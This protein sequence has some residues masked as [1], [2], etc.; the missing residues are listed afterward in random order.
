MANL[1]SEERR[2]RYSTIARKEDIEQSEARKD[3]NLNTKADERRSRYASKDYL[4][5]YNA[6]HAPTR[7]D[8]SAVNRYLNAYGLNQQRQADRMQEY[9][10]RY[11]QQQ[12]MNAQRDAIRNG[13]DNGNNPLGLK[14]LENPLDDMRRLEA[15]KEAYGKNHKLSYDESQKLEKAYGKYNRK[16]L[17]QL[18]EHFKNAPER[19]YSGEIAWVNEKLLKTA[20]GKENIQ[21][22]NILE[23]QIKDAD[24]RLERLQEAYA[25]RLVGGGTDNGDY[26]D[27]LNQIKQ[28]KSQLQNELNDYKELTNYSDQDDFAKY[29][30]LGESNPNNPVRFFRTHND[31]QANAIFDPTIRNEVDT[32]HHESTY[33]GGGSN[34]SDRALYRAITDEEADNYSYIL[35][36]YGQEEADK[37][38]QAVAKHTDVNGSLTALQEAQEQGYKNPLLRTAESIGLGLIT[39]VEAAKNLISGDEFRTY[40]D[41]KLAGRQEALRSGAAEKLTGGNEIG[42]FLYNTATSAADNLLRYAVGGGIGAATGEAGAAEGTMRLMM[43]GQVMDSAMK[44]ALDRGLSDSQAVTTALISAV[45][46]E[47]FETIS[48]SNLKAMQSVTPKNYRQL[49]KNI[50]KQFLG[51]GSEEMFTDIGNAIADDLVNGEKS[52]I[53]QNILNYMKQGMSEE[54]AKKQASVDFALQLVESGLSGGITGAAMGGAVAVD[55]AK[56]I[57]ANQKY[58]E[59]FN[60]YKESGLSEEDAV[61]TAL[62]EV[63]NGLQTV[64]DKKGNVK[65]YKG[66][67]KSIDKAIA[68]AKTINENVKNIEAEMNGVAPVSEEDIRDNEENIRDNEVNNEYLTDM[69]RVLSH[70]D[71][72][73]D[74]QAQQFLSDQDEMVAKYPDK[75]DE[76]IKATVD[77][78]MNGK[79]NAEVFDSIANKVTNTM[80]KNKTSLES[81]NTTSESISQK[82]DKPAKVDFKANVNGEE[83]VITSVN[84]DNMTI[85][86]SVGNETTIPINAAEMSDGASAAVEQAKQYGKRGSRLYL[87]NM[88]GNIRDY[89]YTFNDFY[90]AGK[91]GKEFYGRNTRGLDTDFLREVYDAGVQDGTKASKTGGL[92]RND[93]RYT[94]Q[95]SEARVLDAVG[96]A[97]NVTIQM[98]HMLSHDANGYLSDG[99]IHISTSAEKPSLVVFS[100]EFTHRLEDT[101]P[102]AYKAYKDYVIDYLKKTSDEEGNNVYETREIDLKNAYARQG[103]ELSDKELQDE[104]VANAT[105]SF[106]S[107]TDFIED[108]VKEN[109]SLAQQILDVLKQMLEDLKNVFAENYDAKSKEGKALQ[110]DLEAREEAL[111]LWTNAIKNQNKKDVKKNDTRYSMKKLEN[112]YNKFSLKEDSEG[113]KLSKEQQEFFKDSK[114]VDDEGNLLVMYHGS[115]QKFTEFNL[116]AKGVLNGRVLGDGFYFTNYKKRADYYGKRGKVFKVYLNIKNPLYFT[117]TTKTPDKIKKIL[118]ESNEKKYEEYKKDESWWGNKKNISKDKYINDNRNNY[119]Y[120]RDA[121]YELQFLYGSD[122]NVASTDDVTRILKDLGYDGIIFDSKKKNE[123]E[124]VAFY[125]NQVKNVDNKKPTDNPDIR[126]SLKE[127]SDYEKAIRYGELKNKSNTELEVEYDKAVKEGNKTDAELIV[128]R[129]AKNKGYTTELYHGTQQFGFTKMD[130]NKSD[131]NI[132]VFATSSNEMASSYSGTNRIRQVNETNPLSDEEKLKL[133]KDSG[134]WKDVRYFKAN[135]EKQRLDY[136]KEQ[137]KR[138]N[139]W[140]KQN[141]KELYDRNLMSDYRKFSNNLAEGILFQNIDVE[142]ALKELE[143]LQNAH[144]VISDYANDMWYALQLLRGRNVKKSWFYLD[145]RFE[146][147]GRIGEYN[148]ANDNAGNYHLYANTDGMLDINAQ[149]SNWNDILGWHRNYI[150]SFNLDNTDLKKEGD[151]VVLYSKDGIKLLSKKTSDDLSDELKKDMLELFVDKESRKEPGNTTRQI[152]KYAKDAGYTGVIYRNLYDNGGRNTTSAF[153]DKANVY[154]FFNPQEQLK[155]ADPVTYDDEGNVI[156]LSERFNKSNDDIRFSLK[157]QEKNDTA[158]LITR[159]FDDGSSDTFIKLTNVSKITDKQWDEIYN[160]INPYYLGFDY[161]KNPQGLKQKAEDRIKENGS[162]TLDA[163]NQEDIY[164]IATILGLEHEDSEGNMLSKEQQDYFKDSIIRDKNGKLKVV[165]HGSPKDFTQFDYK[166]IGTTGSAEGYGFYFTDE[167]DKASGYTTS[168]GGKIYEGYLNLTK[169]LSL[170][171]RTLK[172]SQVSKLIK[173]LDPTGDDIVSAY[174]STSDGY[175]SKAWYNNSLNEALDNLMENTTD[176][177]IISEIA[178]IMGTKEILS[179]VRKV[180]GYDGFIAKDKYDNGE[181]YVVFDSNQFKNI[182]NKTPTDNPDIRFSLKEE[183]NITRNDVAALTGSNEYMSEAVKDLEETLNNRYGDLLFD[184]KNYELYD[185]FDEICKQYNIKGYSKQKFARNVKEL[186]DYIKNVNHPDGVD[187]T[188]LAMQVAADMLD[189]GSVLD[190]TMLEMYPTLLEELRDKKISISQQDR[191]DLD[192]GYARFRRKYFGNLT[193]TDEGTEVDTVYEGLSAQY[194]ELFASDITH[195][196]DRLTQIGNVVD[197]FKRTLDHIQGASK[198]ESAFIIAQDI[199]NKAVL[200]RTKHEDSIAKNKRLDIQAKVREQVANLKKAEK[201]IYYENIRL[202]RRIKTLES[203]NNNANNKIAK[204]EKEWEDYKSG[205]KQVKGQEKFYRKQY[206]EKLKEEFVLGEVTRSKAKN[207]AERQATIDMIKNLT[208]KLSRT[209]LRPSENNYVPTYLLNS[210][211]DVLQMIDLDSG[212]RNP[213]GSPT[214]VYLHLQNLK[215]QYEALR[216]DAKYNASGE[217]EQIKQVAEVID[218]IAE[219]VKDKRVNQLTNYELENLLALMKIIHYQINSSQELFK[220]QNYKRVA[221]LSEKAR[222]NIKKAGRE[223]DPDAK[224]KNIANKYL[225]NTLSPVR[226]FKRLEGY[227]KDGAL[228]TIAEELQDGERESKLIKQTANDILKDLYETKE[229]RKLLEEF[230]TKKLVYKFGEKEVVITPEMRVALYLHS[231]NEDNYRHIV[232]REKE[233]TQGNVSYEGGGVV[234]PNYHK[235]KKSTSDTL[236]IHQAE[237]YTGQ[238]V[239][240]LTPQNVETIIKDMN[241]YDRMIVKKYKELNSY[242]TDKL[243][244]TT[245][246][247]YGYKKATVKNYFPIIVDK[248]MLEL[249]SDVLKLDKTIENMGSLK[250]RVNSVQPIYLEG[251][252]DAIERQIDQA[253]LFSGMAIPVRDFKKVWGLKTNETT[254]NREAQ[255][256]MGSYIDRYQKNLQGDLGRGREKGDSF[257]LLGAGARGKMAMGALTGNLSV[258]MKQAASYPTAAGGLLGYQDLFAGLLYQGQRGK[259]LEEIIKKYTPLYADRD[260]AGIVGVN[261]NDM[262]AFKKKNPKL[263]YGLTG[264]IEAVDKATVRR[265]WYAS[266]NYVKRNFK[267]EV[268]SDKFYKEVAKV[269]EDTV[270]R[271]QPIYDTMN[272]PEYLRQNSD[273]AKFLLMFKTQSFQN[274]G[275][276]VDAVGEYKARSKDYKNNQS[277]ENKKDKEA[278]FKQLV[279]ATSSQIIQMAVFTAITAIADAMLHRPKKWADEETGLITPESFFKTYFENYLG[280][281]LGQ[282]AFGDVIKDAVYIAAGKKYTRYDLTVAPLDAINDVITGLYN[283]RQAVNTREYDKA[284]KNI[285]KA[286]E[287]ASQYG[288]GVPVKNIENLYKGVKGNV[289]D[290]A[291]GKNPLEQSTDKQMYNRIYLAYQSGNPELAKELSEGYDEDKIKTKMVSKLKEEDTIKEAAEYRY[292]S[293]LD[294]YQAIVDAY[295]SLGFDE[296]WVTSAISSVM[297]KEHGTTGSGEYNS[298]DLQRAI[299]ISAVQG[300]KVAQQM[301]DEKYSTYKADGLKNDEAKKKALS[302]VRSAITGKYKSQYESG[303]T[304]QKVKIRDRLCSLRV[305]GERL[306]TYDSMKSWNK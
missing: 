273:L 94:I 194:P 90:N 97:F 28:E 253:A 61:N 20:T 53:R 271:T 130:V 7:Y 105:E 162:F 285:I 150:K 204:Q 165:Y 258:V 100:H 277:E 177:D 118:D 126:Y 13:V 295:V 254:L 112:N 159:T 106:L 289:A 158:S 182:D 265:L 81:K 255:K 261:I 99:V 136:L 101:S 299:D 197:L 171:K 70:G 125:P 293:E 155:S 110:D 79:N 290:I 78:Y 296:Y 19:D 266:E 288:L 184:V 124:I 149:G 233:D 127:D 250:S 153:I 86:D 88:A 84:K 107:D 168:K 161:H 173:K 3:I 64:R 121:I 145:G 246:K 186:F 259:D 34:Q 292:N 229:A 200:E 39:P 128:R 10:N 138:M 15:Y 6:Y 104:L 219:T 264:W 225:N 17:E 14:N 139:S 212:Y 220:N 178:N 214:K 224:V 95:E 235:Q 284:W 305:A 222:E 172:R 216:T 174:A 40:D 232:G 195:P 92:I 11:E 287:T 304:S 102:K 227:A 29:K 1:S 71:I 21:R 134:I 169:P 46:E 135:D 267:Y 30:L 164:K 131:D 119:S 12:F 83:A 176:D 77:V 263:Y 238:D 43:G 226:L 85:R 183:S 68:S 82:E 193:L 206:Y 156:P 248:S 270:R 8:G 55:Q 205:K 24:N 260:T 167:K 26:L 218:R 9:R 140:A 133:L 33:T 188:M 242:I 142:Q 207:R 166:Y 189:K 272:R 202:R 245:E 274:I 98:D 230:R 63:M 185:V 2:K 66:L 208:N 27:K 35:G 113:N 163:D 31:E 37:Y 123:K 5:K 69:Q 297:N 49:A 217:D 22:Q 74:A 280:N 281:M 25:D 236:K 62:S 72:T 65:D 93:A 23:S 237:K 211:I 16:Q 181:V 302:S 234:I 199:I 247:L 303:T 244:D 276:L 73:T 239:I 51:E 157:E 191:A 129:Y 268:G 89:T 223:F 36:K 257:A 215:K 221:D 198:E 147:P 252:M 76:I 190:T 120:L 141:V 41:Y 144:F 18:K 38:L 151:L 108:L 209:V 52:E 256:A 103:V 269:W 275:I 298:N 187:T 60:T 57:K 67:N 278:A 210:M 75:K 300:S 180:L 117:E 4:E 249:D 48:L 58:N 251:V 201:E 87:E 122:E 286:S 50:G 54:E 283:A 175:P 170:N 301:Y 160:Y 143:P 56:S 109:K 152:V 80:T 96:K 146:T 44:N 137:H 241:E 306:Y 132:S 243:N 111:K 231:L 294:K 262:S 228:T 116:D 196:A 282:L 115:R 91:Q 279:K 148:V 179:T 154:A 32:A 59:L 213:D 42:T 203:L 192:G 114:A 291:A 240:K 47:L 45:N